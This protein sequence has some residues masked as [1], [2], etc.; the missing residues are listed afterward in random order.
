[1]IPQAVRFCSIRTDGQ[2]DPI[3]RDL[4][5][6]NLVELATNDSWINKYPHTIIVDSWMTLEKHP[7]IPKRVQNDSRMALDQFPNRPKRSPKHPRTN[8]DPELLPKELRGPGDPESCLEPFP[9]VP[10]LVLEKAFRA[11]IVVVHNYRSANKRNFN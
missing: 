3:G 11:L 4:Y 6:G 5:L 10:L 2:A 8:W 9:N 7:K 1:M